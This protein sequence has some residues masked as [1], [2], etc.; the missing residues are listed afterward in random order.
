MEV[1]I[2]EVLVGDLVSVRPGEKIPVDGVVVDGRTSVDESMLTGESLPIEKGP[3]AF[4]IGATLNK[5]GLIKFEAT[6]IGKDT[7][8]AQIIRLVEDAQG[9]KAP[10]QKLVDEIMR[11]PYSRIPLYRETPDNI[12]GVLHTKWLMRELKAAGGDVDLIKLEEIANAPWFI[13]DTTILYDQLQAFRSRGEHFAFIVD[14]Y[15][16]FEGIVTLEDIF[17]ES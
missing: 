12:V 8:L 2:D 15:G 16:S 1:P 17:E 9:S 4:V 11:C 14:E 7:A 13:P 6:K 10:I 5:M 3:G